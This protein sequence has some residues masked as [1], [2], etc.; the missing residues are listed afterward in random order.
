M[1][2]K[3]DQILVI[4]VECTC[5]EGDPPAGEFREIIEVGVCSLDLDSL[6]RVNK[7]SILVKPQNSRISQFCTKLTTLTEEQVD[8]GL[9]FQQACARLVKR[10]HSN[11]RLWASYGDFD[12]RQFE[13]QCRFQKVPYPFGPSHLN[14][15][16]LFALINGLPR[17]LD[18]AENLE[19]L[20]YPLEGTYHRGADDAWNIAAILASVLAAKRSED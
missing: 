14:V 17:E 9:T 18:M 16:N 7:D 15:K 5:W 12:R 4:D 10:Y 3:L 13:R 11:E 19:L 1:A 8:G 20:G 6:E 2:K